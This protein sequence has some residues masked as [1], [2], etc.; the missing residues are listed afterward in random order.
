ML[1]EFIRFYKDGGFFMYILLA[2]FCFSL[3]IVFEKAL[4][5]FLVYKKRNIKRLFYE[6]RPKISKEESSNTTLKNLILIN[7]REK[8]SSL[9]KHIDWLSLWGTI[10]TLTGLLGTIFGL[11]TAFSSVSAA[12]AS[13][14]A[15]LL[16]VGISRAMNT[17]AAGIMIALFSLIFYQIFI[18][19][20]DYLVE[21][22]DN[23]ISKEYNE[24]DW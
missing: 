10:S 14:K 18:K 22:L 9:Q 24:I 19:R 17:T 5:L 23:E 2:M 1:E 16:A 20:V 12:E 11:I 21:N 3:I 13:E 4:L 7:Y 8:V 15:R 6:I